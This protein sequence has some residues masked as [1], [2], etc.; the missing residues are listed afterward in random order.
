MGKFTKV[1]GAAALAVG[2]VMPTVVMAQCDTWTTSTIRNCNGIDYELWN[3]NNR[4]TVSMR[5][6]GSST[7]A[8]GGSFTAEWRNTE[9]ILF[10]SGKKWGA[11]STQNHTQIGNMTLE[12]DATWSSNDNVKM[13]GVYGW[14]YF[15]QS[16]IPTRDENGTSRSYSNQIEY[17]IIQERG[18][19][20]PASGGTNAKQYGTGTIDGITYQFWVADRI[21]QPMLT[22]NGNFKQFFSVPASTGSH[23]TSGTI[24]VTAHF[25][26]W[27]ALGM[28]MDGPLYEVAM[29]VE[30]YTGSSANSQG[31]ATVR[32][33]LLTIGGTTQPGQVYLTTVASPSIGGTVTPANTTNHAQN[34]NVQVSATAASGW[35]FTGWSGASTSTASPVSVSMGTTDKTVTANFVPTA[36]GT[37][38]LIKDGNFPG[39]SL[40][41][42]W[43]LGQGTGWGGSAATASVSGGNAT[44]NITTTGSNPWEPQLTQSGV[45]L[46]K[47]MN[48]RLTFTARAAAARTIQTQ[49]GQSVDPWDTYSE[50]NHS[51]TTADQTYTHEFKMEADSDPATQ[52]AF[53]MGQSTD[54]VTIS[55]VRLIYILNL[56]TNIYQNNLAPAAKSISG[57]RVRAQSGSA[58]NVN[59]TAAGSGEAVLKLYSLKG[60]CVSTTRMQTVAGKN[61]TYAFNQKKLSNGFYI[62]K[63]NSGGKVERSRVMVQR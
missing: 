36:D 41:S 57:L 7:S 49:F 43:S 3:Q 23:R 59:F 56:T 29:K 52:F 48:Y 4:G 53:N 63:L 10:R 15:T 27:H 20:N 17:Y 5:I 55:N 16:R 30:S 46:I 18:S 13:L 28:Y 42:N 9:N 19:F 51:L 24:N 11:N 45:E 40:S 21:N 60:D 35:R 25:N 38:N 39:T 58:V 1:L 8:N 61:Y 26:A 50:K 33:S 34:A 44:I 47:G 6:T 12:F 14:A 2:F 37:T 32:K 22:G 31:S 62:V 54:N